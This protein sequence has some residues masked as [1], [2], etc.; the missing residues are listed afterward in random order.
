MNSRSKIKAVLAL[1][2]AGLLV[3][4][5]PAHAAGPDPDFGVD[6]R[7]NLGALPW[8]EPIDPSDI[9]ADS[10]SIYV[11]GGTGRLARLDPTGTVDLSYVK[12]GLGD[13]LRPSVLSPRDYILPSAAAIQPDGKLLIAGE[14]G[15]RPF[16]SRLNPDGSPDQTFGDRG[17][18]FHRN[19]HGDLRLE[20]WLTDVE[21]D[22]KGR[23]L[24][25]GG[26]PT[27]KDRRVYW[28][29]VKRYLPSGKMDRSF[30]KRGTALF[31]GPG[32]RGVDFDALEITRGG[33]I[34]VLRD[35]PKRWAAA[36]ALR[37]SGKVD[38]RFAKGRGALNLPGAYKLD[39][40]ESGR[41]IAF[42]LS[43]NRFSGQAGKGCAR[44]F[45]FNWAGIRSKSF[46][47]DGVREICQTDL[48]RDFPSFDIDSEGISGADFA[49]QGDGRIVVALAFSPFRP[50]GTVGTAQLTQ[51]TMRL[52]GSGLLDRSFGDGGLFRSWDPSIVEG[53]PEGALVAGGEMTDPRDG[54]YP[55]LYR[56]SE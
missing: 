37:S 38:R 32:A 13:A 54:S 11:I 28:S 30:A 40:D 19:R 26:R 18:V 21:V 25:A 12:G 16:L 44:L 14:Y 24:V 52:D 50:D 31:K 3:S 39:T 15:F 23:I 48:R 5:S 1:L 43:Y 22:S 55:V 29:Y 41:I 53:L 7:V 56:F 35:D 2:V 17:S 47:A 6:G 27:W 34:L 36:I 49:A 51:V 9:V 8:A 33:R 10:S 46:S 42:G 20:G 45:A 4:A